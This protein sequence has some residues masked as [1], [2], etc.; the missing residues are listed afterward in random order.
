MR[1]LRVYPLL[2]IALSAANVHFLAINLHTTHP[3]DGSLLYFMNHSLITLRIKDHKH[4]L[5]SFSYL[6]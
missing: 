6:S 3:I 2:Y 5:M 1:S 4:S